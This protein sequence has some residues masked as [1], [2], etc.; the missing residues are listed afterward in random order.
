MSQDGFSDEHLTFFSRE[1]ARSTNEIIRGASASLAAA[2]A[3]IAA[4]T[5]RQKEG[6]DEALTMLHGRFDELVRSIHEPS[7][8]APAPAG[9]RAGRPAV[10]KR[11][12]RFPPPPHRAA[13][14]Q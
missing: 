3:E 2:T 14:F 4:C 8:R 7:P 9:A 10:A 12:G 6:A 5:F 13:Q 11:G 1:M